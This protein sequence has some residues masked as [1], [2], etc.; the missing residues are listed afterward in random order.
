MSGRSLAIDL[1]VSRLA[2]R[3]PTPGEKEVD[4]S[5]ILGEVKDYYLSMR[6]DGEHIHFVPSCWHLS[7]PPYPPGLEDPPIPPPNEKP[8]ASISS[9]GVIDSIVSPQ[10]GPF[11]LTK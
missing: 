9:L 10:H 4:F 11:E 7:T 6:K 1:M 5:R 8:S 3:S 2:S